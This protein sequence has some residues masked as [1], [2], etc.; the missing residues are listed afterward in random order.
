MDNKELIAW[1]IFNKRGILRTDILRALCATKNKVFTQGWGSAYFSRTL[2]DR[3]LCRGVLWDLIDT[4]NSQSGYELTQKG[5]DTYLAPHLEEKEF[6]LEFKT[7]Q[8]TFECS[9]KTKNIRYDI[10]IFFEVFGSTVEY[11]DA[12]NYDW[13]L[14][15]YEAGPVQKKTYE[16]K[17]GGKER[18]M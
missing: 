6:V 5:F 3:E 15:A 18:W 11:C 17:R 10:D 9:L 13:S 8:Q 4:E 14:T 2:T 12:N 7:P 16:I 1:L